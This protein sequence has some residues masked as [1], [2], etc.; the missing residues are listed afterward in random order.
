LGEY[1]DRYVMVSADPDAKPNC[2]FVQD[3]PRA[4]IAEAGLCDGAVLEQPELTML[5]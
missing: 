5:D 3:N 1:N 4:T 2:R